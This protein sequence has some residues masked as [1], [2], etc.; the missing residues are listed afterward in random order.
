MQR[1]LVEEW[2]TQGVDEFGQTI[3]I[4]KGIEPTSTPLAMAIARL[5]YSGENRKFQETKL[6]GILCFIVDR[7]LK[8]R[9]LRLYDLNTCELL[10]Q[11]ELYINFD[12]TYQMVHEHMWCFPIVK[13]VIGIEFA[14]SIDAKIFNK[15]IYKFRFEG[16]PKEVGKAETKK[17]G[18]AEYGLSKPKTF[19][20]MQDFGWDPAK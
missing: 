9:F 14:N 3:N 6:A 10:F 13:T 17:Y 20:R 5:H 12:K 8:S 2:D 11:Q 1:R 19:V 4:K 7:I 16:T 15:L 18:I